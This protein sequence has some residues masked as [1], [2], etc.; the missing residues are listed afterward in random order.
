MRQIVIMAL[1]AA[2]LMA[3]GGAKATDSERVLHLGS[4][5]VTESAFRQ[6][7]QSALLDTGGDTLCRGLQGLSD[8]EAAA[9]LKPSTTPDGA[10]PGEPSDVLRAAAI[11]KEECARI[12]K[13][14]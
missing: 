9:A 2:L 14:E 3:C 12:L 10:T 6:R 13:G 1:A 5:D 7:T 11:V 4:G 8:E